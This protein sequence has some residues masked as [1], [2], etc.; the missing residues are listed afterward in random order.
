MVSRVKSSPRLVADL[1]DLAM[2][3]YAFK[4]GGGIKMVSEICPRRTDKAG[5]QS[6]PFRQLEKLASAYRNRCRMEGSEG[7]TPA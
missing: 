5:R 7:M 1:V 3:L 4:M 2:T 6:L